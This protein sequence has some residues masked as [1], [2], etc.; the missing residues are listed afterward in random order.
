MA[1]KAQRYRAE[2]QR[3]AQKGTRKAPRTAGGAGR[4]ASTRAAKKGQGRAKDRIPNQASHNEAPVRARNSSYELEI[5]AT[6]RPSRKQ[7]RKSRNR[8]KTDS[9]LRITAMNRHARPQARAMRPSG[10]PS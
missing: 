1:T 2:M 8:Q 6:S 3:A 7:T 10:N 5:S 9:A 4:I